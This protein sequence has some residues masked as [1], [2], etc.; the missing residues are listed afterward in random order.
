M[1]RLLCLFVLVP[2]LFVQGCSTAPTQQDIVND[3]ACVGALAAVGISIASGV[4][5][6]AAIGL[7]MSQGPGVVSACSAVI[8]SLT[9][10]IKGQVAAQKLEYVKTHPT[11]I[12]GERVVVP[13]S[14]K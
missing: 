11:A 1:K 9:S 3:V 14:V 13:I 12:R 8:A 7:I 6:A 5:A 10:Q 2:F 4:G